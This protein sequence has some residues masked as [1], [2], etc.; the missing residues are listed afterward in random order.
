MVQRLLVGSRMCGVS[1]PLMTNGVSMARILGWS[2][3]SSRMAPE[4]RPSSRDVVTTV[5]S[6]ARRMSAPATDCVLAK[7]LET[8]V[9]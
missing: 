6:S 3:C 5:P 7:E 2:L 8:T 1:Q 9:E 4:R